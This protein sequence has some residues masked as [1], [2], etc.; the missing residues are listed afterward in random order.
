MG[1][2]IKRLFDLVFGVLLGI[3]AIPVLIVACIFVFICSPESSPIFKQVRVGYKGKEFVMLKLRTMTNKKDENGE[4][5]PDSERLKW[6][7][8]IIRKTN[9]D[10]L[11]QIIHIL[12]G[13]MSFIGPRPLLPKEMQV[14]TKKEQEKRQSVLP[15]IVGWESVNED[16]SSSRAEMAQFDLYYV[17]HWSIGLDIKIFFLTIFKIF[18]F[19][20]PDDSLR[21]PK[22]TEEEI[23]KAK[24][25]EKEEV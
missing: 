2:I 4:Y 19:S 16:K 6:W 24:E 25:K 23:E 7:G 5:L 15:G 14:M 18:S 1:R 13:Q 20:R 3:V 10:E 22:L 11:T 12:A 9:I 21:A 17:D 8:K